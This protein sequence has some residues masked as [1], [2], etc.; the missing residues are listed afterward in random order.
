MDLPIIIATGGLDKNKGLLPHALKNGIPLFN[1][2]ED[3]VLKR[4]IDC[5]DRYNL[6]KILRV[7]ADNPFI[8]YE[9]ARKIID[10]SLS[11]EHDY[12]S[13][14]VNH[15]PAILSHY[16][17]FSEMVSYD[18]LVK[19]HSN[20]DSSSDKEHVTPYIYN[21]PEQFSVRLEDA[22]SEIINE[23]DIRLTVDTETDFK[24]ASEV[25]KNLV[26]EKKDF[27]YN[28]KDVL[29]LI[30]GMGSPIKQTMA[31]QITINSKS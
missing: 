19:A 13:Y 7:C 28:F 10:I 15:Q 17:F 29:S 8:D 26:G 3:D 24:N 31:Q 5:A 11:S 27:S 9:L 25:L 21:H 16:G 14:K 1:G 6:Q 23:K 18:A 30:A 12:V 22:P 4:F 2:S 20:S